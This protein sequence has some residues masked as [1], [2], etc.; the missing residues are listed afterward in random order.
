MI[1]ERN[2]SKES[3]RTER[4]RCLWSRHTRVASPG[5]LIT[6]RHARRVSSTTETISPVG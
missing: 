6:N 3:R 5:V 1:V 2:A 4:S